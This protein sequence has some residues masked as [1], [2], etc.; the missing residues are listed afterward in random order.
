[1]N[2]LIQILTP[3]EKNRLIIFMILIFFGSI[4]E[5]IGVGIIP[6]FLFFVNNPEIYIE[7]IPF[8]NFQLFLK[9]LE[10]DIQVLYFLT[11]IGIFFVLKNLFLFFILLY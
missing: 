8:E 4:L 2:K 6:I 5:S 7:R 1:M 9:T 11:L 3:K 10:K